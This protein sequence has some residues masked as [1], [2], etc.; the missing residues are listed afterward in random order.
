MLGCR[1]KEHERLGWHVTLGMYVVNDT[2]PSDWRYVSEGA[3][4]IVFSYVGGRNFNF[5]GTVLRLRKIATQSRSPLPDINELEL[6]PDDPDNSSIEFQRSV[7]TRLIP[8]QYLPRLECV[9]V[10]RAWLE[11]LAALHEPCRPVERRQKDRIDVRRRKAVLATDLVGGNVL[12]VEIKVFFAARSFFPSHSRRHHCS[13]NGAF[14]RTP[15]ISP[16]KHYQ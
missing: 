15:F 2:E 7:I 12:A 4:T 13:Q 16:K 14:Y 5:D 1:S 11:E 9:R 3:T 6:Q 10:D 8:E